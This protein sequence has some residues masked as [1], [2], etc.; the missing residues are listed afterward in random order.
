MSWTPLH[1]FVLYKEIIFVN[2]YNAKKKSVQSSALWQKVADNLN[3]LKDPHFIVDKRSVSDH[4]GILVQRFNRQEAQELRGSGITPERTE[5]DATVQQ[6]IAMQES[7]DTE[8]QEAIAQLCAMYC[9]N[10]HMPTC[11]VFGLSTVKAHTVGE[12]R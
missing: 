5:V 1:D 9:G 2:L 7:A 11:I 12:K 3:S 10:L 8:L 4:I 6:I